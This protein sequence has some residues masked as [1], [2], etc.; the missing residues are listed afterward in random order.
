[1]PGVPAARATNFLRRPE[2]A[3]SPAPARMEKCA[4]LP[5]VGNFP[6]TCLSDY[7]DDAVCVDHIRTERSSS[8]CHG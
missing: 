2:Y 6:P 7:V 8:F 3:K 1:L 5:P 4:F